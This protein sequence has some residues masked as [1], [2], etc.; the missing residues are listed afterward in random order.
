MSALERK[1]S[2]EIVLL[3][4]GEVEGTRNDGDDPVRDFKRLVEFL[5]GSHHR[6]K[7]LPRLIRFGY[8]E[9]LDLFKLM[10]AEDPPH[11]STSRSSFFAETGRV[12][13]ILNW[14]LFLRALKPLVG[15][16]RGNGLF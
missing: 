3:G 4:G 12:S 9:L 8:T 16:E 10:D 11:I 5:R 6:V 13:G 15:M 7:R 2:L 1:P 14:E